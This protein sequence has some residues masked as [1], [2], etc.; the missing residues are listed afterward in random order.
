MGGD[1]I[2]SDLVHLSTGVDF[3][4]AVIQVACGEEPN[5]VPDRR[6]QPARVVYIFNEKDREEFER[7]KAEEPEKILRIVDDRHLLQGE[8]ITDSSNRAGCYIVAEND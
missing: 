1:C 8:K 3:V 2:G 6:P 5:L 7:I 4:R